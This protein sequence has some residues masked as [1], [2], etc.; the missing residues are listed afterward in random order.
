METPCEDSKAAFDLLMRPLIYVGHKA[1]LLLR[2][3]SLV[4]PRM[5]MM[6]PHCVADSRDPVQGV[7]LDTARRGNPL[8]VRQVELVLAS[9]PR[10]HEL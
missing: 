5:E 7:S 6:Y 4:V 3:T 8:Y 2:W 10:T 9:A 1:H